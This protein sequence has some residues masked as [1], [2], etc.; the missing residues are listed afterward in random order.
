MEVNIMQDPLP[1]I[2]SLPYGRCPPMHIQ[3]PSWRQLLKLMAKL[4]A[5]QIEPST[6]SI[7]VT[8]G[9]LKLRTVVQFFKVRYSLL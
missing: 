1:N 5:T 4:S 9:E 6:E 2:I 7:A 8:K 3:A